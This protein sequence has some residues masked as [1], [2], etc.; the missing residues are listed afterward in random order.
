MRDPA[1]R[2][3][4]ATV[5]P[6]TPLPGG[7]ITA[8]A[9]VYAITAELLADKGSSTTTAPRPGQACRI[10]DF[11]GSPVAPCCGTASTAGL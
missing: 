10:E 2:A 7:G 8:P 4:E 3:T 1:A 6:I 9:T 5:T 11:S